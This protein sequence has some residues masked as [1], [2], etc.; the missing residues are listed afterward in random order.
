[1]SNL[2][3]IDWPLVGFSVLWILG[4]AVVLTVL[5]FAYYEA[6]TSGERLRDRLRRPGP[7]LAMNSGL[8]LFCAG[9]A[10]TSGSW[11]ERGLWGALCLAFGWYAWVARKRR[12]QQ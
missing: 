10:G 5:G 7:Q 8:A 2:S 4:L 1:M 9:M 6:E 12:L 11:W 3:L